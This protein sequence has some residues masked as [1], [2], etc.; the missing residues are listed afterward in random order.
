MCRQI[1]R[2]ICNSRVKID[3]ATPNY[4]RSTENFQIFSRDSRD[5]RGDLKK[6]DISL[7]WK[8]IWEVDLRGGPEHG[9]INESSAPC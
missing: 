5:K 3:Q 2:I 1:E 4:R 6:E 7:R 8:S 9:V